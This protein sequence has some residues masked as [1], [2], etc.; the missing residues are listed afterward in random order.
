MVRNTLLPASLVCAAAMLWGAAWAQQVASEATIAANQ[1][2]RDFL[3]FDDTTDFENARRGFIA[4]LDEPVIRNAAGEPVYSMSDFA[5]LNGEAP[6]TVNPSLWRQSQ[7]NSIHGLFE[8]VDGI[9]QVR[10]FDLSNMSI[11]RGDSGWIVVDPLT[12]VE[13]AQAAIGLV[14]RELGER[15]VSAVIITH[16]HADHFAGVRAVA[17]ENT[18]I[19]APDGFYEASI[20]ENI[21]AGNHMGRR[22]TYMF[23]NLLSKDPGGAVGAG[24]GQTTPAGTVSLMKPTETIYETGTEKTIDGVRFVFQNTPGAE[25][26]AEFMFYLPD[27]KA[28]CQAEEINHTLHNLYTPRGAKVRSGLLWSKY[29]NEAIEMWGA[30]VEVSFGSHHWPTWG[31]DAIVDFMKKQRDLYKYIHDETLRLANSGATMVEAAEQI[32]L[33]DELAK[34][35]ANRDYY[36]TVNHNSKAQYQL[37]FGWFD[38]NPANLHPLP[39]V[40]QSIKYVEYMG[41]AEAVVERARRDFEAGEYRFTATAL[42]HVV[43]A[44]P[45]NEDARKLLAEVYTQL[46]YQAESGPWRNFYLTG[47][48]ELVH[49]VPN[50]D[51]PNLLSPDFLAGMSIET[52]Y[53]FL[54]V[55]L[56]GPKAAGKKMTFNL[57]F[58]DLDLKTALYVENGVLNTALGRNEPAADA[59]VTIPRE[60]LNAVLLG[61]AALP[62][63][64]ASG[65]VTIEGAPP[66]FFAFLGMLDRPDRWFNIVTP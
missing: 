13:T 48:R 59:T 20:D 8:V 64:M 26:P 38:G 7:L 1:A 12:S 21:L 37:Y 9:Y 3:P 43:F 5:F 10:G 18:P 55:L 40:E 39:P 51:A 63:L 14:N 56:N 32:Q 66:Q 27:F 45:A 34:T 28:L 41:G 25:A 60:T 65:T 54:G 58:S 33:P 4:T 44:D 42:N 36:G 35:F 61:Q 52:L 19:I 62:E 30:D 53:D 29:V 6:E 22:A 23:G 17:T 49:G 2:V 31:N 16:S 24:L 47:A 15:P 11:I 50:V 57:N 46:G